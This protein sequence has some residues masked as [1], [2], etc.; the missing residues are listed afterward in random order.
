[1]NTLIVPTDGLTALNP[2][3]G[4]APYAQADT[5][6]L[7]RQDGAAFSLTSIQLDATGHYPTFAQFTGTTAP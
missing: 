1:M 3:P 5:I 7:K 6:D 2:L 4:G